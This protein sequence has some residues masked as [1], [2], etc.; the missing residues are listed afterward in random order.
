MHAALE[1]A[2]SPAPS[3]LSSS[4]SAPQARRVLE[5]YAGSGA[6]SLRLAARGHRVTLVEAFAPAV[7]MARRAATEQGLALDAI[8]ADTAVALGELTRRG[9]RFD[10]V[11]VNPPRR[12]VAPEVRRLL[13][14]LAPSRL[15]YVSCAPDTLARDAEQLGILGFALV[16]ATPF[17]MIPLSDAVEAL[18][19]FD[20][21]PFPAPRVLA[22]NEAFLAVE[23]EPHTA[24]ESGPEARGSLLERVQRI[25]G[26]ARAVA[27][28]PLDAETSG[29]CVFARGPEHADS[30]SQALATSR[31]EAVALVRGVIRLRSKLPAERGLGVDARYERLET[32]AGHS[33]IVVHAG[34]GAFADAT[35]APRRIS[36]SRAR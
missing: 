23:K 31:A 36:S 12:G 18:A 19:V 5:L 4:T 1:V 26:A 3:A 2:L 7:D 14:E 11:I 25:P 27:V 13:A 24:V 6:L 30:V 28:D 34:A 10:T 16:S 17:D 9:A 8:T 29:V 33:L 32:N 15:L 35:R 20:P 22:E 21:A